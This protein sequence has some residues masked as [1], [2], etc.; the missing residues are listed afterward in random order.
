MAQE[1]IEA[2]RSMYAA[3]SALAQSG[4]CASYV[5][6]YW[7]PDGE[8][9]PVE[10]MDTIRGHDAIVRWISRWLEAW[11][12]FRDEIEEV[13]A[14]GG[15]VV[16][17]IRVNGRGRESGMEISQRLFHV[18]ELRD[19]KILRLWEYLDRRQALEAAGLAEEG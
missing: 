2:V 5:A 15:P 1:N 17:A 6:E 18:I 9:R 10:E 13:T 8:Y 12:E 19:G 16:A 11:D 14:A 3:F 7:D 4:D